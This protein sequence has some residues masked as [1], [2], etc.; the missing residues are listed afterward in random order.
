MILF[1]PLGIS[2]A[3]IHQQEP[4]FQPFDQEAETGHFDPVIRDSLK[5]RKCAV[6]VKILFW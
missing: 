1:G 5:V 6:M 2:H 3:G 4:V